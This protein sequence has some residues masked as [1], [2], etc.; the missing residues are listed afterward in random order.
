MKE[1]YLIVLTRGIP[2]D[3]VS[4]DTSTYFCKQDETIEE[5]MD[6]VAL[7]TKGASWII[8]VEI[9]RI[10]EKGAGNANSD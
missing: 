3:G 10:E 8:R 7:K 1:K 5:I 4:T 6:W 9:V 2:V